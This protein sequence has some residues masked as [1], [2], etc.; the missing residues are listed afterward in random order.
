MDGKRDIAYS[1][2]TI[3]VSDDEGNLMTVREW[4][5]RHNSPSLV[6]KEWFLYHVALYDGDL[7]SFV[8]PSSLF[9][10]EWQLG[11]EVW[12]FL[13]PE[14]TW[15]S[16]SGCAGYALLRCGMVVACQVTVTS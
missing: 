7:G 14:E 1:A 4:E 11:D 3:M 9:P 8:E 13:S 16:M 15:R 5:E 10:E 12:A 6:P 2:D